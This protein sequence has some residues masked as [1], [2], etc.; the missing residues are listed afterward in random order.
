MRSGPSRRVSPAAASRRPSANCGAAPTSTSPRPGAAHC[1]RTRRASRASCSAS[2][3]RPSRPRRK[4]AGGSDSRRP[5]LSASMPRASAGRPGGSR[6]RRTG[7]AAPA[8]TSWNGTRMSDASRH[9]PATRPTRILSLWL[10]R[11][12][13]DRTARREKASGAPPE[14]RPRAVV[15]KADNALRVVAVDRVAETR[16]VRVGSGLADA[17]A[18]VPDLLVEEADAAGDRAFLEGLADWCGRYTPLV[19]LDPPE[20]LFLDITGCAHLFADRGGGGGEARLAA[21]LL[22]RLA[23]Q[24][25]AATAAIAST[26]GAAWAA[27]RF[28]GPAVLAPG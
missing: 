23:A 5:V 2:A 27:A 3:Q 14:M 1:G 20:G 21:D 4:H 25:L 16:G 15:A 8:P 12:S 18:A 24:G 17:R 9:R 13:T 6:S 28:S 10:P 7:P 11:L 22:D 19:A 26:A